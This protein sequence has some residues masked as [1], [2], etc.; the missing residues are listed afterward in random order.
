M[1]R[2][3]S[4]ITT[5]PWH[6]EDG[7]LRNNFKDTEFYKWTEIND[8]P[9]NKYTKHRKTGCW[10]NVN[11]SNLYTKIIIWL[12]ELEEQDER[13]INMW[14]LYKEQDISRYNLDLGSWGNLI[15]LRYKSTD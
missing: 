1:I 15:F 9:F 13:W 14:I 3:I 4:E 7:S 2:Q 5:I 11:P 12:T 10:I 8:C 6:L